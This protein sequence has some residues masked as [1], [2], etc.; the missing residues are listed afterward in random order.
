MKTAAPS[1]NPHK[2]VAADMAQTGLISVND[3]SL[4]TGVDAAKLSLL[5]KKGII[6][7]HCEYHG[8]R[9]FKFEEFMAWLDESG[10]E[11]PAIQ[12]LRE[13]VQKELR[14]LDCLYSLHRVNSDDGSSQI[15]VVW[16]QKSLAA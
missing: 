14:S 5:A 2:L 9:F 13:T 6:Q 16:K 1:V 7:S 10:S 11:F 15:E 4:L 8:K 3:L 12:E